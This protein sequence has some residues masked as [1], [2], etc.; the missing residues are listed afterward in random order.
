MAS[1]TDGL[2]QGD[3]LLRRKLKAGTSARYSLMPQKLDE[4]N[5]YW[6]VFI[7]PDLN[8]TFIVYAL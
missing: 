3:I 7:S 6:V 2:L 8:K 4:V 1:V 5:V